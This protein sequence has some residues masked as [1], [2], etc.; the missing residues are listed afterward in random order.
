MQINVLG[1]GHATATECF[2]TCFTISNSNSEYFLI[3]SGGGSGVLRQLK[4]SNIPL[5][6]IKNVFIS[7]IHMDHILGIMWL[8]RVWVK[9]FHKNELTEPICIY[10]NDEVIMSLKKLCDILIPKDFL[11][12]INSKISLIVV[13]HNETKKILGMDILFFDLFAKKTKQ[14]G[15][16]IKKN[17]SKLFTFIGDEACDKN[18]ENYLYGSD[19]LWADAYMAGKEAEEY[20]PI[21]KH[22]HSTVKYVAELG[23]RL[24]VNNLILSHTIDT[25]LKQRKKLFTQDAKQYFDG[26]VYVPDDFEIIKL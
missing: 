8:I 4:Q 17:D 20:N 9:K 12:L 2:N 11:Y 23:K 21:A 3:D 16:T 19:W 13:Q 18:T 6:N 25:N 15:F 1:T 10:G 5:E 26:N 24:K 22:H 7:H 14:Y